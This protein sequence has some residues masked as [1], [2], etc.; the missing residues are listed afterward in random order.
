MKI[1]KLKYKKIQK[2]ENQRFDF[3]QYNGKELIFSELKRKVK[4]INEQRRHTQISTKNF[5][6]FQFKRFYIL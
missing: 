5:F 2:I 4:F 1:I 3:E 6:I